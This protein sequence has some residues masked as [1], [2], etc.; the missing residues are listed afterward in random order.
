MGSEKLSCSKFGVLVSAPWFSHLPLPSIKTLHFFFPLQSLGENLWY[1]RVISCSGCSWVLESS[2]VYGM[3]IIW[4]FLHWI[5]LWVKLKLM[6]KVHRDNVG[7][8][9]Q[10]HI[11]CCFPPYVTPICDTFKVKFSSIFKW[12]FFHKKFTN[13]KNF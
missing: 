10:I 2:I 7:E 8:S 5:V 11:F 12:P 3:Y 9:Y 1:W 13:V 4:F 6:V